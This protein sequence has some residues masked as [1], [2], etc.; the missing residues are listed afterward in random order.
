MARKALLLAAVVALASDAG[1]AQDARAVLQAAAKAMGAD[2]VRTIQYTATGW[3]ALVGQS[4][5][6]NEDWP[7][8][9]VTSYTRVIDYGANASREDFTR[10]RGSYPM[11]GGGA[12]FDGDQRVVQ[13]VSDGVAWNLQGEK[14]VPPGRLYLELAPHS[15]VR[16]LEIILSPHGFLKAAMAAKDVRVLSTPIVG[17]TNDGLTGNGRRAT[18]VTFT[19]LGKYKVVGTINDQNLV[20]LTTTW[21]PTAVYGDTLYEVRHLDYEDFGGVKF[22]TRIHVHQGDPV[23]NP[24]HNMMEIRVNNVQTNV[25][26]P[27]MPV[28][29][30]IR[31]GPAA[32]PVRA[33]A[34]KLADGVWLIAGGSHHSV[35]VEFNDHIAMIEAPLGE[36]RSIAVLEAT[37]KV[38]PNKP[39]RYI[40]NTHHHFD[41]SSGLRTYVAMGS[42]LVTHRDNADFY[43]KVMFAP[44]PR[45][46][47]P[48]RLSQFYP[49]FT[50]SR[51]PV[52]IERVNQKYV[53][54][55]GNQILELY[56]M[57]GSTHIG[58]M[59]LA[60]LPKQKILV[61]ADMYTPPAPGAQVP[62]QAMQGVAALAQNI[63]RL[64]LDVA[65]HATLHGNSPSPNEAFLKLAAMAKSGTN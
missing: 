21:I 61:N 35:A 62:S 32:P 23:F 18:L 40:I 38:I 29:E 51:R 58:P 24:A 3:N 47:M 2:Q 59:L 39:V 22:P 26:V 49:N 15:D 60:Y 10:R 34:T 19:A 25:A 48:D 64:R 4:Y 37:A 41:H 20:E 45:T 55:D 1:S 33:E 13:V 14:P 27:A 36:E 50:A 16:Q 42:T 17:P 6:L 54:S 65:T 11:R 52:P 5:N 9:E 43:E 44:L 46:V 30:E 8:F 53:L 28:P 31:K 63:Q 56:P 7:R 12:P 57:L